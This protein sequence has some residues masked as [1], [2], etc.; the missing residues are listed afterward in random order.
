MSAVEALRAARD[1]GV[2]ISVEGDHLILQADA[3][4]PAAIIVLLAHHKAGIVRLLR[5]G[6]DGWSSEDWRVFFDERASIAEFDIGLP[7][8]QSE[9]RAFA[10]CV[11]EWLDR[12]PV[13]SPPG[14][15]MAC[16]GGDHHYDALL[17][18]GVESTGHV[19]LHSRCWPSWHTA[20]KAEAVI[21]LAEMGIAPPAG[22]Q[23]G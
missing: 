18:F 1:A 5:P 12:N 6:G 15:C 21:A 16:G 23:D 14:L 3:A 20:R 8:A 11:V 2:G 17:P 19:W 4:P 13:R 9:E 10:W 7:R 22:F